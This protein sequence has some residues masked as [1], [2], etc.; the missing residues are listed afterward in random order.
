MSPD[1]NNSR[2]PAFR[3]R[4]WPVLHI[5]MGLFFIV[6]GVIAGTMRKFGAV[7]LSAGWAFG[8]AALMF[9]YG[10]FRIWRGVS[11]LRMADEEEA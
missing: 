1:P 4:L 10:A 9:I 8:F 6:V 2:R 5:I 7:Q 11:D 3:F